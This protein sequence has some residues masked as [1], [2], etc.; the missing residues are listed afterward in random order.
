MLKT[1]I[2]ETE[3]G[4]NGNVTLPDLRPVFTVV[5]KVNRSFWGLT[6]VCKFDS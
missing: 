1:V 2:Y 5:R 4:K 3:T 6:Q